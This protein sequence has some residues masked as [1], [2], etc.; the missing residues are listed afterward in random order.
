[1]KITLNNVIPHP[2]ASANH[3]TDSLWGNLIELN[4]GEH[5]ILNASSGKGKSTFTTTS[6]GLRKDY[7]GS[8]LYNDIDI[9]T[10]NAADWAEIRASKIAVVFQDLQ[11][12]S[13]LTVKDNLLLKNRLTDIYSETELIQLLEKLEIDHK[14]D[15]QCGQLSMGQQQRVAIIRA[16]C[17]PYSWLI[18]DEPFSH[19][20][21]DI[22]NKC[23]DLI[24][25]KT[26]KNGAGFV[27]TT[28]NNNQ[29]YKYDKELTL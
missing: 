5:I 26:V 13:Q 6:I 18:M 10:F 27:L 15:Q 12:F 21:I 3:G 16:I 24:H 14:W 29:E 28:L 22:K 23:L 1:M 9:K 7:Q 8:I 2:L 25:T 4:E 19:L 20:D 11:L 17:Q